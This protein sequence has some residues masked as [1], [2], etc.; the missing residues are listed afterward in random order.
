M[1]FIFFSN[2]ISTSCFY[3]YY[4]YCFFCQMPAIKLP[5]D[6][7]PKNEKWNQAHTLT[8]LPYPKDFYL[9]TL[10]DGLTL[11]DKVTQNLSHDELG[12]IHRTGFLECVSTKPIPEWVDRDAVRRGQKLHMT[13]FYCFLTSLCSGLLVIIVIISF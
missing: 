9:A 7:D 8:P 13:H 5:A 2:I 3:Y 4:H 10:V 11:G 12:A 1:L 6:R